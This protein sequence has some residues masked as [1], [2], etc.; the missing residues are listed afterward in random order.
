MDDLDFLAIGSELSP[1]GRSPVDAPPP[2]NLLGTVTFWVVVAGALLA[3]LPYTGLIGALVCFAAL[4]P[5]AF[6]CERI[7]TGRATNTVM[8][9][10]ALVG[11]VVFFAL[12]AYLQT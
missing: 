3:V 6:A 10:T 12:G 4:F 9:V 11:S 7:R 8:A 1:D 5:A 2:R